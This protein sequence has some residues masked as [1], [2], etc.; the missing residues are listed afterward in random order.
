M[1]NIRCVNCH[2]KIIDPSDSFINQ[3]GIGFISE[4]KPN[5]FFLISDKNFCSQ[6]CLDD[7]L[8]SKK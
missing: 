1:E 3:K 5:Q 6:K 2:F 4:I 8:N 7:Y